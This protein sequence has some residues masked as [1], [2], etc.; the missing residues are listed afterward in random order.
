MEMLVGLCAVAGVIVGILGYLNQHRPNP[1]RIAKIIIDNK[2]PLSGISSPAHLIAVSAEKNVFLTEQQK[3]VINEH[4][5]EVFSKACGNY[6]ES[7]DGYENFTLS[8]Y[9]FYYNV[10]DKKKSGQWV[11]DGEKLEYYLSGI[12]WTEKRFNLLEKKVIVS[13]T[14]EP[15]AFVNEPNKHP[16]WETISGFSM[17]HQY[18]WHPYLPPDIKVPK[19]ANDDDKYKLMPSDAVTFMFSN[20]FGKMSAKVF[21]RD[22]APYAEGIPV[23]KHEV[24]MELSK[25]FFS[26]KLKRDNGEFQTYLSK[27]FSSEPQDYIRN[28]NIPMCGHVVFVGHWGADR[29]DKYPVKTVI[30]SLKIRE[31]NY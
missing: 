18:R 23:S 26:I 9:K 25:T 20:I 6:I 31:E 5:A 30:S 21:S 15:G 27:N 3:T 24:I 11:S 14:A 22:I 1:S 28:N 7:F 10:E 8:K 19:D 29:P 2:I 13:F 4:F 12:A 16:L 17:N